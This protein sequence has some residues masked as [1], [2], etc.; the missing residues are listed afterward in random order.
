VTHPRSWS[1]R[2][3]HKVHLCGPLGP[4]T[5][6][7]SGG[8]G[9]DGADAGNSRNQGLR[10]SGRTPAR[11]RPPPARHG[12]AGGGTPH[13]PVASPGRVVAAQT[14]TSGGAAGAA[15]TAAWFRARFYLPVSHFA[16]HPPKGH[17]R[18]VRAG[19]DR[20]T[21]NKRKYNISTGEASTS[22]TIS[23]VDPHHRRRH[24]CT[25][26]VALVG[27]TDASRGADHDHVG[28]RRCRPLSCARRLA[29]ERRVGAWVHPPTPRTLPTAPP[30]VAAT[31][32][33]ARPHA[34]AALPHGR[35]VG[36]PHDGGA[37]HPRTGHGCG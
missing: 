13:H 8:S 10:F 9:A 15:A 12:P 7:V 5:H 25:R 23:G 30:P 34:P 28:N 36:P 3:L 27:G 37:P 20:V 1:E 16:A 14:G 17:A 6:C 26:N 29:R 11:V 24:A 22:S 33:P 2:R 31:P 35:R 19:G 4:C 21:A 18:T 32:P